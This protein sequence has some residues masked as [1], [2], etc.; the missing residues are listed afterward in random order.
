MIRW[1]RSLFSR[2]PR[3]PEMDALNRRIAE[4]RAKHAP[5][6]HLLRAKT[7]LLHKRLAGSVC[8]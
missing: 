2:S 1:L 8:P 4:A 3:D 5:V 7:D 6:R